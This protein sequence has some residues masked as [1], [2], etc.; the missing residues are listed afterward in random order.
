LVEQPE[1]VE[2]NDRKYRRNKNGNPPGAHPDQKENNT[3]T[4][5]IDTYQ[6]KRYKKGAYRIFLYRVYFVFH[7]KGSRHSGSNNN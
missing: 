5:S 4:L 1:T 3:C 6:R 7:K 2:N